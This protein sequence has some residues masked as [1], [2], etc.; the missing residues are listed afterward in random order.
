MN[1]DKVRSYS[2]E[3]LR[4]NNVPIHPHLPLIDYKSIK[5]ARKICE[6]IIALYSLAGI[7][8]GAS[9]DLFKNW[10]IENEGWKYLSRSEQLIFGHL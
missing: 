6:R 1:L 9:Q 5:P 7:A 3:V 4:Q 8:N 10:L 2:I